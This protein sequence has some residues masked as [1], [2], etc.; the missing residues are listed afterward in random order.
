MICALIVVGSLFP[1]CKMAGL[2]FLYL[3]AVDARRRVL[4][5][6]TLDIL[7]HSFVANIVFIGYMVAT[8]SQKIVIGEG[9]KENL[10]V[11]MACLLTT[12]GIVLGGGVSFSGHCAGQVLLGMAERECDRKEGGEEER[13]EE[14]EEGDR[15]YLNKRE[16]VAARWYWSNI[17]MLSAFLFCYV[18][19]FVYVLASFTFGGLAGDFVTAQSFTTWQMIEGCGT[20]FF[21]AILVLVAVVAPCGAAGCAAVCWGR[22]MDEE[23][24]KRAA[25]WLW[26]MF[27]WCAIDVVLLG[28]FAATQELNDVATF[29]V[30]DKAPELCGSAVDCIEL[31][32]TMGEG[33]AYMVG[34]V[35]SLAWLCAST[36]WQVTKK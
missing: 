9:P 21:S 3:V 23:G 13:E 18:N 22:K 4:I 24:R 34:S 31:H 19:S 25:R 28:T 33:G 36:W 7:G 6:R 11:D 1:V 16:G 2:L 29:V 27:S 17:A 35:I 15:E 26:A 20:L 8:L 30:Q 5:L 32:G 14:E 12:N 10:A